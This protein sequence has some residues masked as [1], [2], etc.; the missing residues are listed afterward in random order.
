VLILAVFAKY[1]AVATPLV[2]IIV[3]VI[4]RFYLRTSRQVR[5]LDIEAKA[6]L[7]LAFL[8]TTSGA[9]TIRAF[10]W[11]RH[12]QEN[13]GNLLD[14]SQRP[15]YL[16]YCVQQWLALILDLIVSVLAILLVAIVTTWRSS[17]DAGSV[18][19]ALVMVM[20]FNRTLMSVVKYWTMLET[21]IGAVSRIKN[22]VDATESEDPADHKPPEVA[23]GWPMSGSVRLSDVIASHK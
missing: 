17:F 15:V 21:S 6:P 1:L 2:V 10:G 19:V 16:L 23:E 14:R 4:Q 5:L 7:F 9:A 3:F 18:G 13:L 12:F 22:F 11:E 20:T 8:E